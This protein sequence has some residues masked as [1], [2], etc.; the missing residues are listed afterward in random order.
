MPCGGSNRTFAFGDLNSGKGN[1]VWMVCSGI[2]V[3]A[4]AANGS[5]YLRF[6]PAFSLQAPTNN[7]PLPI[8]RVLVVGGKKQS[9]CLKNTANRL[10]EL[11]HLMV[12]ASFSLLRFAPALPGQSQ[13]SAMQRQV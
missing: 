5:V 8:R 11:L 9:A 7:E 3:D 12:S 4:A 10:S 2:P 13:A 1:W 6:H